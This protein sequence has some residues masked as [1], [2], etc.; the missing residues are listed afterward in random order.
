MFFH[1]YFGFESDSSDIGYWAFSALDPLTWLMERCNPKDKTQVTC[2]QQ[3]GGWAQL[4]QHFF[5][6][7]IT[8]QVPLTV[9]CGS[10]GNIFCSYS[11]QVTRNV[12]PKTNCNPIQSVQFHLIYWWNFR[13]AKSVLLYRAYYYAVYDLETNYWW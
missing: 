6:A 3:H 1:G 7:V 11:S 10:E 9:P 2:G 5:P 13:T 8:G 12:E 4:G